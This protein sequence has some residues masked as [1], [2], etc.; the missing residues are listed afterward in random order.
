LSKVLVISPDTV[1]APGVLAAGPGIRY[2]QISRSLAADYGHRVT[3]AVPQEDFAGQA[4]G[5]DRTAGWELANVAELAAAHDCVVMPHV[6]SGL[7]TVYRQTVDPAVPTAVDLYDPV[8]IENIGLQPSSDAGADSFAGYLSGV[9]PALK[10]GDYFVCA[11]E[12]QRYYYLGVLN[13]LGRINPLTYGDNILGLVPF[14]VD[15]EAP[16]K[17][18]TVMRGP[19]VDPHDRIILWFSGIYPWFDAYTLIEAMPAVL[20]K[21]PT[22]KLV[23]MG[24][25]HPRGHAPDG[26]FL[27]TRKRAEQLNLMDSSVIF[28]DWQP[29]ED[30]ANWYLESDLAVTTHKQS[31]E[32]ELSHR[33]RVIDFLWGGLPVITSTGDAVGEMLEARGCGLT[34]PPGD[35]RGLADKIITVLD[36]ENKREEMSRLAKLTAGE[37]TWK[38]VIRPLAEFCA[39]PRI[40]ADRLRPQSAVMTAVDTLEEH[41]RLGVGVP[42]IW[43]KLRRRLR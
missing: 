7:S 1:P 31:L 21:V 10:R 34:V 4:E 6:H 37:L 22:A 19:V 3:L 32:T 12:R 24:G 35:S 16:A 36:N 11:N 20:E 25:R 13:A 23:I 26:E 28:M 29:Y 40:A 8:L 39:A 18:R 38:A 9:V 2:W 41:R 15:A 43:S 27:R 30:R 42:S 5:I 17:T 14:G 33:T